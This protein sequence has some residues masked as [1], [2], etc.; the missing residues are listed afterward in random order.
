[1]TISVMDLIFSFF[2]YV[3]SMDIYMT[4]SVIALLV[5]CGALLVSVLTAW[6]ATLSPAKLFGSLSCM[7]IWR[8]NGGTNSFSYFLAPTLWL[9][10]LGA[11]PIVIDD[12]KL[13]FKNNSSDVI[14]GYPDSRLNLKAV[15]DPDH[16]GDYDNFILAGSKFNGFSLAL[17]EGWQSQYIF[18]FSQK[19]FE[20]IK[21]LFEV[22]LLIRKNGSTVWE[23]VLKQKFD[24]GQVP[25][26]LQDLSQDGNKIVQTY[27]NSYKDRRH[28][29]LA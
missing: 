6:F 18:L 9:R 4:I 25:F 10:N 1:M 2:A 17:K 14:E 27:S 12:M 5:S 11:Q 8:L 26:H 16:F 23:S 21:G 29:I 24:F 7:T 13:A 22:D 19:E 3:L 15:E 20:K 28:I